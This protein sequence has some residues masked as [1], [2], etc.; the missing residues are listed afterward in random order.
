MRRLYLNLTRIAMRALGFAFILVCVTSC[1]NYVEE[2]LYSYREVGF[3]NSQH[4]GKE[5]MFIPERGITHCLDL[6]TTMVRLNISA[7]S[8]TVTLIEEDLKKN[9]GPEIMWL[10]ATQ[11]QNC[12]VVDTENFNCTGL[13]R[14]AGK[15]AD[16][17]YL[18]GRRLS[19]SVVSGFL[20]KNNDGW[21]EES[22]LDFIDSWSPAI[23]TV[24]ASVCFI[25]AFIC[26]VKLISE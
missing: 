8:Q 22:T 26:L 15:F 7:S 13:V 11:L 6:L 24:V 17:A 16:T 9:Q 23:N 14:N 20:T 25:F 10:T 12:K 2:Q 4:V 21:L 1:A 18:G 5:Y 3:C 19:S